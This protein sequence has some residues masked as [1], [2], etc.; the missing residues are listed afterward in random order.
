MDMLGRRRLTRPARV[1]L[2]GAIF[3]VMTFA[4]SAR[5]QEA[6][7]Q[8]E[9][10]YQLESLQ[11]ENHLDVTDGIRVGI[12]QMPGSAW[13]RVHIGEYDLGKAS[14]LTLTALDGQEQRFDAKSLEDWYHWSA[15]FNGDEVEVTL[16][17]APGDTGVYVKIDRVMTPGPDRDLGESGQV[18]SICND[19]D[20]RGGSGD[21]RVGRSPGCTAWLI[22]N[23][24]VL[25]AGHCPI[26]AGAVVEFNVPASLANGANVAAAVTNQYPI[27][28]GSLR[29]ENN[30]V[31]EDWAVFGLNRNA[32]TQLRAHDVQGFFY[33]TWENPDIDTTLRITGFGLDNI[34]AGPGGPGSACCD[35]GSDGTCDS[36]CN[37]T[38]RTQQSTTGRL[39]DIEDSIIEHDVDTMP[40]N[41]GSPIIWDEFGE[42]TI[43]IHTAGG[44][45]DFFSGYNNHGTNFSRVPLALAVSNFPGPNT[46]YVDWA[47]VGLPISGNIF[48]PFRTVSQAVAGV[49]DGGIISVV[50]G[51]YP[52][53]AGNTFT[54]GADG[55]A[56]TFIAP[57]GTVQIGN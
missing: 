53:A 31:G 36:N 13:M 15:F 55:K 20:D 9:E 41:S 23:G 11:F 25:S 40:A 38:S 56:M 48:E 50:P 57:V 33:V 12:V 43:G 34:P 10:S 45:D 19:F 16:H 5:G 27:N 28:V 49:A 54:A 1:A 17:V 52:R 6:A 3:A 35:V 44:C 22:S 7:D 21:P 47:D 51:S 46:V 29:F 4:A 32:T 37:A 24:A 18:A 2:A 14:Y 39:D 8:Y 30:G 42:Y 26:T